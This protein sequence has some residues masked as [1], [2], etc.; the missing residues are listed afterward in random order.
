MQAHKLLSQIVLA[1]AVGAGLAAC[2]S[3]GSGSSAASSSA[4]S[5]SAAPTSASPSAASASPSAAA[6]SSA[7]KLI[8]ANWT[9]FFNP[10][11]PVAT[12]ISLLQDGQVF[13]SVIQSQAAGGLAATASAKVTS[14]TVE[15]ATQAKVVY[16]ILV[17]GQTAL[18]NQNGVAVYQSGTWKV[19]LASFC[20]LL[21]LENG[22]S[23][24]SLPAACKTAG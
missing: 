24:S 6:G 5:P 11:T 20:G 13:A 3:S 10:K 17:S 14:V 22:G 23:S 21:T 19:G 15:S 2:G 1:C 4:P 16:S 18:A 7:A 12:R 9:E 8:A